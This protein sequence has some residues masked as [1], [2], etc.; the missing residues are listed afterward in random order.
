MAALLWSRRLHTRI[1]VPLAG[2]GAIGAL[3]LYWNGGGA[4]D[5]RGARSEAVSSAGSGSGRAFVP[6]PIDARVAD[7]PVAK[8]EALAA[9]LELRIL[10][11]GTNAAVA[12]A[13]VAY[14]HVDEDGVCGTGAEPP[15][16]GEYYVTAVAP[17]FAPLACFVEVRGQVDLW[18]QRAATLRLVL[19]GGTGD[20]GFQVALHPEVPGLD[21][22]SPDAAADL[23]Q[24]RALARDLT[25]GRVRGEA[26]R[27]A[28]RKLRE[29]VAPVFPALDVRTESDRIVWAS[30]PP[31]SY[32]YRVTSP[33]GASPMPPRDEAGSTASVRSHGSPDPGLSGRF[34]L[35]PGGIT[36]LE[37]VRAALCSI[38]GRLDLEP[39]SQ[40]IRGPHLGVRNRDSSTGS[41]GPAEPE[42]ALRLDSPSFVVEGL[43]P[44]DK[45]LTAIHRPSPAE[46]LVFLAEVSG[47]EPGEERDV[48]TIGVRGS[49]LFVRYELV[50][51]ADRPIE[52]L[53]PKGKRL[54]LPFVLFYRGLDPSNGLLAR[55][56]ELPVGLDFA[57]RGLPPGRVVVDRLFRG[58]VSLL[59]GDYPVSA[60]TQA[61]IEA[62]IPSDATLQGKIVLDTRPT[63]TIP[64]RLVRGSVQATPS[65]WLID[66]AS[67][68]KRAPLGA[69]LPEEGVPAETYLD[70][71]ARCAPGEYEVYAVGTLRG[72]RSVFC[73][74]RLS[75]EDPDRPQSPLVFEEALT[76]RLRLLDTEGQPVP[77]ALAWFAPA[78]LD[79]SDWL[80]YLLQAMTDGAGYLELPGVAP[81]GT[82][83]SNEGQLQLDLPLQSP[84]GLF[85]ELRQSD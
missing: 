78:S 53:D 2:L 15:L 11:A 6:E 67:G 48:G 39:W 65:G 28:L 43:Q 76:L 75:L 83:F 16:P 8:R 49:D 1:G 12:G 68:E 70:L 38:R 17:G 36:E 64:T 22:R 41:A 72:G 18:L 23:E 58:P 85:Q 73:H 51:E 61:P 71:T 63:W 4:D 26:R 59:E 55:D 21:R 42:R 45:L 81:G 57:L 27:A 74:Q 37:V 30:L 77:E 52:P 33:A 62:S 7:G 84:P 46:V 10:E 56:L 80:P 25:S 35:E 44:G 60:R 20:E 13:Q 50:D 19:V 40:G 32:R 47:L 31:G 29:A 82:L 79:G 14:A 54:A 34:E 69:V 3:F 24:A 9:R 5:G 66:R